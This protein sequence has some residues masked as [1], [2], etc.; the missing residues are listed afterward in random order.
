MDRERLARGQDLD[1]SDLGAGQ[2]L[3]WCGMDLTDYN[4]QS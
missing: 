1:R 2:V 4:D 3:D